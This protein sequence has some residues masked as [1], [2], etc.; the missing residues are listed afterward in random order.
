V[1]LFAKWKGKNSISSAAVDV[2]MLSLKSLSWLAVDTK[3]G[4]RSLMSPVKVGHLNDL[5]R[6]RRSSKTF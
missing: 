1:L 6:D 2:A 3:S 4:S 5:E